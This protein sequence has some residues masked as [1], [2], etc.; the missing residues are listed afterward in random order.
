MKKTVKRRK[1]KK[2]PIIFLLIIIALLAFAVL[3]VFNFH[4]TNIYIIGNT[5]YTDQEIID[6]SGLKNYPR[7]FNNNEL[8]IKKRL[9]KDEIIKKVDVTKKN[10]FREV[11][12]K[13]YENK[14]LFIYDNKVVLTNGTSTTKDIEVPTLINEVTDKKVYKH[15]LKQLPKIN[16]KIYN[17]ISEIKYD[18]N[19]KDYNRFIMT[20]NDGNYVYITL[21][22]IERINNYIDIISAFEGK[23]GILY[24]DSG[25][26]F[27]VFGG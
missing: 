6:K 9:E 19:D 11:Y 2:K 15:L 23:K 1:V 21:R 18:P 10:L 16:D 24:L 12:I 27:E 7:T 5:V 3:Y 26:Y 4:I 17:R 20:M 22:K 25:E 8:I 13:I 14:P